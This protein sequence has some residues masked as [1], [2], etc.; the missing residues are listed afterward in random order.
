MNYRHVALRCASICAVAWLLT[1]VV[2][3]ALAGTIVIDNFES[4][5]PGEVHFVPPHSVDP[6]DALLVKHTD[7]DIIGNERDMLVEVLGPS[8]PISAAAI[9]GQEPEIHKAGVLQVATCGSSPTRVTLQYDGVDLDDP[10]NKK[11]HNAQSLSVDLTDGGTNDR[12]VLRFISSDGVHPQ[13]LK[14]GVQVTGAPDPHKPAELVTLKHWGYVAD[15]N[16]KFEHSIKFT[17]FGAQGSAVFGNINSL[18][19]LFNTDAAGVS[20]PNIDI[21]LDAIDVVPEPSVLVLLGCMFVGFA[22]YGYRRR[23]RR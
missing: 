22:V 2:P 13:G 1:A 3:V 8:G 15:S 18:M 17:E 23:R 6:T 19:F 20:M 14:I 10:I 11:L 5:D 9:I 12:L 21:V 16:R 4:P 7:T